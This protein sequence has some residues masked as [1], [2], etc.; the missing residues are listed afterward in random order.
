MKKYYVTICRLQLWLVI[1]WQRAVKAAFQGSSWGCRCPCRGMWPLQRQW[2]ITWRIQCR[3]ARNRIGTC[4]NGEWFT[5]ESAC[6]A[7]RERIKQVIDV[8]GGVCV[9]VWPSRLQ[10]YRWRI[11]PLQVNWVVMWHS[12]SLHWSSTAV[13]P[14]SGRLSPLGR[15]W[16]IQSVCTDNDDTTLFTCV[17]LTRQDLQRGAEKRDI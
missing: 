2:N 7:R 12:D 10:L 1:F 6:D 3:P 15:V 8:D 13:R 5:I 11:Y 9:C 14:G 4:G 17:W 16:A